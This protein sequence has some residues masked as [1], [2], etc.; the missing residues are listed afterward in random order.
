VVLCYIL[1]QS[2][3]S[4]G[5]SHTPTLA[6][7]FTRSWSTTMDPVQCGF[8]ADRQFGPSVSSCR[9][10]FDFTILFEEV[11]LVIIPACTF[12][13]VACVLLLLRP[14]RALVRPGRLHAL[15]LVSAAALAAVQIAVLAVQ[16]RLDNKTAASVASAVTS[17]AASVLIPVL[18]HFEHLRSLRPSALMV[19][20][21]CLTSLFEAVRARTYWLSGE[22]VALA[23]ALSVGLGIRLVLLYLESLSKS[24]LLLAQDEKIAVEQ[25]AGPISRTLF[26][27][28]SGLMTSGYNGMLHPE[29]IGPIDDRLLTT[30]LRPKFRNINDRYGRGVAGR[31]EQGGIPTGN[32]LVV[33]TFAALGRAWAAPVIARLA[34]TAFTF[35]QPF[36]ANE[37]LKYLQADGPIPANHGY[38][39]IGAA[40]L[41]YVGIAAAT[42]WYWHQAYRCAVMVRLGLATAIFDKVLRLPEGEHVQATATTLMVEDLQR[43]MSATARGHEIWAG[44]IETGVAT[45]LLYRQLGPSCFVML[46]LTAGSY[47]P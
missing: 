46:G 12:I 14:N 40:F 15:K 3:L 19:S 38:G 44:V 23:A 21:L 31:S 30:H 24:A 22:E 27:W 11:V 20:F 47:P 36:L 29:N 17:A 34:V 25:L 45:W 1:Y 10:P 26:Y 33:L 43:I 37:A 35:T 28:L 42:G 41:C 7:D 5:L 39:L 32:G 13:P 6:T 4:T 8:A 2:Q 9:R 18:S 16:A